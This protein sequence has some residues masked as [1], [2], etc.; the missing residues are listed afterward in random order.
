MSNNIPRF[1]TIRAVAQTK[2]LP[3][4]CLRR[5][6]KEGKLPAIKTGNKTLINFDRL[7]EMLNTLEGNLNQNL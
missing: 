6:A 5:M 3:E 4:R 1:M 7:I 2:I